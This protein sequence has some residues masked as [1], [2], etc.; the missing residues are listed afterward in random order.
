MS[1]SLRIIRISCAIIFLGGL[2]GI[3]VSSIAGNN[4]G[5]VLTFGIAISVAA[6]V[7]IAVSAT[8]TKERLDVFEDAVAEQLEARITYLVTAGANEEEVRSL[9]RDSIRI[10][11]NK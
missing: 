7:L 10:G 8:T 2:V 4:E 6:V 1:T 3:I 9:V 11:R 5:V